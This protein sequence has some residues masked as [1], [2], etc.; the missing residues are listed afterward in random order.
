MMKDLFGKCKTNQEW[1]RARFRVRLT[2]SRG[3]VKVR[4]KLIVVL[5]LLRDILS[6][7]IDTTP[8]SS[9]EVEVTHGDDSTNYG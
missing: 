1:S 2:W 8:P 5:G 9:M 6:S 7:F 4:V 3:K